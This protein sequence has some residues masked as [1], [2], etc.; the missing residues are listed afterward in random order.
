MVILMWKKRSELMRYNA[1]QSD[2][3][4]VMLKE[5]KAAA[6][7]SLSRAMI[8]WQWVNDVNVVSNYFTKHGIDKKLALYY[9]DCGNP[10]DQDH[11]DHLLKLFS[12]VRTCVEKHIKW[13]EL[14]PTFV[15][16]VCKF[17]IVPMVAE[18]VSRVVG[19]VPQKLDKNNV[20]NTVTQLLS[21]KLTGSKAVEAMKA[22]S[23]PDDADPPPQ[24][25]DEDHDPPDEK[26]KKK[27]KPIKLS[28]KSIGDAKKAAALKSLAR[29]MLSMTSVP[30]DEMT[31]GDSITNLVQAAAAGA[32]VLPLEEVLV[33]A[34][35]IISIT[36]EFGFCGEVSVANKM[37]SK[38]SEL[39][40]AILEHTATRT[41]TA[42]ATH[43]QT[44]NAQDIARMLMK[45]ATSD[46]KSETVVA[47]RPPLGFEQF[48]KL[49]FTTAVIKLQPIA[50]ELLRTVNEGET[51]RV[52]ATSLFVRVLFS[53]L[54]VFVVL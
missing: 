5:Y 51:F 16:E 15:A 34:A 50:S 26:K 53:L 22:H 1:R 2:Y 12:V 32:N 14:R 48:V 30:F 52:E 43:I 31:F 41:Q 33:L 11:N 46:D 37:H 21:I 4:D 24:L 25:V 44:A 39:R 54:C 36:M 3:H 40:Q 19:C 8:G 13:P 49:N 47:D 18:D 17:G 6:T 35:P 7:S 29:A 27:S 10:D 38:Y 28:A 45:A 20:E 9:N 23:A 42:A